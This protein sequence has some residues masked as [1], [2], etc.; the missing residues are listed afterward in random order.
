MCC[1]SAYSAWEKRV[2][3]KKI[4]VISEYR[5]MTEVLEGE[6]I[7]N[8]DHFAAVEPARSDSSFDASYEEIDGRAHISYLEG[9]D[10]DGRK[11]RR[12]LIFDAESGD[13]IVR[14]IAGDQ[15]TDFVIRE[16]ELTSNDYHVPGV[17]SMPL[18][19]Y[20]LKIEWGYPNGV[21]L[22]Y[23]SRICGLWGR[24]EFSIKA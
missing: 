17:G 4:R 22:R 3:L 15:Q 8:E 5:Y 10:E 1:S 6:Q 9:V 12:V 21:M 2:K 14:R 16:G 24:I 18:D 13:V 20:G 19:V 23:Y 7:P 11:L